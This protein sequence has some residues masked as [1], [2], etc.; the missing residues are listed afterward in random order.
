M[1]RTKDGGM[2]FN[3]LLLAIVIAVMGWVGFKT[4]QSSEAIVALQVQQTNTSEAIAT[5][6]GAIERMEKK[7][8]A[9]V[10]RHEYDTKVLSIEARLR[11]IDL[12][13]ARIKTLR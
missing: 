2:N 11:E 12:E 3:T 13:L 8:E 1:S 10:P 6:R 4:T 9:A 5:T 7:L